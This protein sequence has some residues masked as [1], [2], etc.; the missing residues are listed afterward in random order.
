MTILKRVSASLSTGIVRIRQP[1]SPEPKN[2]APAA[3]AAFQLPLAFE[4]VLKDANIG[5][6]ARFTGLAS[7]ID[8]DRADFIPVMRALQRQAASLGGQILLHAAD[9]GWRAPTSLLFGTFVRRLALCGCVE[10]AITGPNSRIECRYSIHL[11]RTRRGMIESLSPV[12]PVKRLSISD[13]SELECC[14]NS[15]WGSEPIDAVYTWV[16]NAD[17]QWQAKI[18]TYRAPAAIDNDRFQQCD[19]LR[20]SLRSLALNA[21]WFRRIHIFSNCAPPDWFRPGGRFR[22]VMH[23]DVIE[24]NFLPLFNSHAIETFLHRLPD[25]S[26]QFVYFND[27]FFLSRPVRPTDF[28]TSYGQAVC[29]LERAGAVAG[30]R[31]LKKQGVAEEWQTAALNGSDLLADH[32][33]IRPTRLHQHVPYALMKS[34]CDDLLETFAEEAYRTRLSRFRSDTD[35]SFTSFLYHHFA[36]ARGKGAERNSCSIIVRPTNYK[37]FVSRREYSRLLFFCLNDGGGSS[38]IKDYNAF[39][40]RFLPSLYPFRSDAEA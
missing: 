4:A 20:Y 3:S 35:V 6:T 10:L 22:W 32:A 7:D 27:D 37:R 21:P 23:E 26:E 33:G 17:P 34:V 19:E 31:Q 25:L 8:L 29:R 28:F 9:G 36:L 16:N 39:K 18:A 12:A 13:L 14:G 15:D 2:A 30:F 1:L 40:T 24:E 11:W 5:I 38:A